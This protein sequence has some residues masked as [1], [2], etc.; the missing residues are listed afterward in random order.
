MRV[1][2]L[3]V[4]CLLFFVT[5]PTTGT[6]RLPTEE[7]LVPRLPFSEPAIA[8]ESEQLR[9][10]PCEW[11]GLGD[12]FLFGR[13]LS[14]EFVDPE[15]EYSPRYQ[16]RH[17]VQ[18]ECE[19]EVFPALAVD[20][21]PILSSAGLRDIV[22]LQFAP[23]IYTRW[24]SI[25]SQGAEGLAWSVEAYGMFQPGQFIGA[26]VYY[27]ADIGV[28]VPVGPMFSSAS[29][30]GEE[31]IHPG[32]SRGPLAYDLVGL[33]VGDVHR[34]LSECEDISDLAGMTAQSKY[35]RALSFC[36]MPS[37]VIV[38]AC[39]TDLD[40]ELG[41]DCVAGACIESQHQAGNASAECEDNT[42]CPRGHECLS[43]VCVN[44]GPP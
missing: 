1:R 11:L 7:P 34:L 9:R 17:H 28:Y 13:V 15:N 20:I 5:L 23:A 27:V 39:T 16:S 29:S 24:R 37:L 40:C 25:P 19:G 44:G 3:V 31:R 8:C 35:R 18:T 4:A 38:P 33:T 41:R 26:S 36:R 14:V 30:I 21:E 42:H 2:A 43:G 6:S 10:G 32:A 12:T 22:R